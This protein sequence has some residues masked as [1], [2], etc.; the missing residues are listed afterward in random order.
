M[1]FTKHKAYYLSL[2]AITAPMMAV[3]AHALSTENTRS[4]AT[5]PT[6]AAPAIAEA[7]PP[8][9]AATSPLQPQAVELAK[10]IFAHDIVMAQ[11]AH[12]MD[13]TLPASMQRVSDYGELEKSYPGLIDVIVQSIRTPML[14][15]YEEKLPLLWNN[16]AQ[17]YSNEYTPAEIAKL[18]AY[19][20]SP[21]GIRVMA[22]MRQNT[23]NAASMDEIVKSGDMGGNFER[24]QKKETRAAIIK[25]NKSMSAADKL[26]TFRFESSA[27]GHKL[28]S[29]NP[30]LVR[31][32][33]EWDGYFPNKVMN[34]IAK[35]RDEAISEFVAKT[36]AKNEA[37][38]AA[39]SAKPAPK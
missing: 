34:D 23:N 33:N 13:V 32:E 1:A 6:A 38:A 16:L 17:I 25:A 7:A 14:K 12:T 30:L 19:Y 9:V 8:T 2:L 4:N 26:V 10:L 22:S 27:V 28:M 35:G 15:A 18:Y 36:D 11:V 21:T 39:K 37:E 24:T 29:V 3:P 20:S 31:A 5:A